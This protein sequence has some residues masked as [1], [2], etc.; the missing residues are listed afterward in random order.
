M[1]S[2]LCS[3]CGTWFYIEPH[4][5]WK[6]ICL[7]CWKKNKK[8]AEEAEAF[9]DSFFK[10]PKQWRDEQRIIPKDMMQRL[11]FLCHPDKHNNSEASNLATTWLIKQRDSL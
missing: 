3:Q 8:K 9:A 2:K 1:S 7:S 6:K 10:S 11:I 4:E 5:Q